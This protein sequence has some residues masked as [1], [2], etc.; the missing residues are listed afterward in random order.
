M[1]T[2]PVCKDDPALQVE[3]VRLAIRKVLW[4]C[5]NAEGA[6]FDQC[7]N[8][9]TAGGYRDDKLLAMRAEPGKFFVDLDE[10]NQR[11][12]IA[13]AFERYP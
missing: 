9:G 12:L 5:W 10:P 2:Y 4:F 11:K 1:E 6:E 3:G 7:F 13:A 8:F